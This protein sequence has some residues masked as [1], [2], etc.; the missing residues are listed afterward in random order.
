MLLERNSIGSGMLVRGAGGER[1]GRVYAVGTE[2]I[3]IRPRFKKDPA[4][5]VPLDSVVSLANGDVHLR[6][7]TATTPIADPHAEHEVLLSVRSLSSEEQ[8]RLAQIAPTL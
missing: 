7:G 3:W 6:A 5:T 1:L 8:E 4:F 2:A